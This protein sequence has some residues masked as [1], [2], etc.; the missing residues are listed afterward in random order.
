MPR[1]RHLLAI[2][3]LT[4][5][6]AALG[7]GLWLGWQLR[8]SLPD[9][10]AEH[11]LPGLSAAVRVERDRLGVPTVH[12]A[13]RADAARATGFVHAQDRYFQ[14]DL[15][16]RRAA[17]E[18]AELVGPA[19]LDADKE[20]RIHRLRAVAD[21]AVTHL[22]SGDRAVLAAYVAGVNAGLASL[23]ARP[24]EY[25]LLRQQPRPWTESDSMLVVLSMFVAQQDGGGV[26][27]SMLATM[28]DVLPA[29]MVAFLSP[30]G[31]EWDTPV[32][33]SAFD[34]PPVPGPDVYNPRARRPGGGRSAAAAGP[35]RVPRDWAEAL[36]LRLT[37]EDPERAGSGSNNFAVSGART[38]HGGA[39]VADDMHFSIRVPNV[40]YRAA[41]EWPDDGGAPNR[42]DGVTLPGL[43]TLV[44]GSNTH[45]A[46][47]FTTTFGD[48]SDIVL[49]ERDPADANRYRA[50]GGMR[51]FERHDETIRVAGQA[52]VTLPVEWT[53]WGPLLKPD[54]KGRSR[55]IRWMAHDPVKVGSSL[56][57]MESA[58]TLEEGLA[59]AGGSGA[60][61]FN[62]IIASRDGRIAWTIY[63]GMPRREGV[64]GQV[65][66]SWA[67]GRRGW[68]GYLTAAEHPR[69]V[70]PPEGRLWTANARVVDGPMRDLI[71]DTSYEIG[72][73]ARIIRERL[74][75]KE[76]FEPRDLLTIQL[77]DSALFLERWRA[78]LLQVLGSPS[79]AGSQKR[80]ELR[81]LVERGWSGRAEPSSVAYRFTRAFRD[82]VSRSVFT[83]L[84]AECVQ[85]DPGFDFTIE[86]KREGPLWRL[87]T[88]RPLHML[89]PAYATWEAF[90]VASVDAVIADAETAFGPDLGQRTWGE[91]NRTRYRHPLSAALP[92]LGRWLDM[93]EVPVP[94]DL[95]TPRMAYGADSASE[96][97]VVSPGRESEGLMQM[98][99]GQSGHPFSP[100]YADSHPAWISGEPAP[101]LPG[102]P[103]HLLTLK[104]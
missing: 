77:D 4:L 101:F 52:D 78:L 60:P 39:L 100:H 51:R 66:S 82:R 25:L 2:A 48:W 96:R 44:A 88:E 86:R 58:R 17:G 64:D 59:S 10:D 61:A 67:D 36:A 38:A 79:A 53:V 55:A 69:V 99:T 42:L 74:R 63:G 3:G 9:L 62:Q 26:Y 54:H 103:I 12:A 11:Q 90:L 104:P 76:R 16:R 35:A 18:L 68:R 65:P 93:P 83:F 32:V 56:L 71:G 41:I 21:A 49:V 22:P 81:R 89:D 20:I 73:R 19:A 27:E 14:M 47:G 33:G 7:A 92:W 72:S 6:G 24:P 50:P 15:T 75:A 97:F 43:P 31:T 98:P 13:N 85:A 37:L 46:W 91:L 80:A 5:A 84:V 40:W 57:P 1:P 94:G 70:D 45:V 28:R 95:Y 8:A 87:V 102:P 30:R 23:G 29:G 34:M